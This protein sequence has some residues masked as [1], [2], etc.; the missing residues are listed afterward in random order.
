MIVR[1]PDIPPHI[2]IPP[3]FITSSAEIKKSAESCKRWLNAVYSV[4]VSIRLWRSANTINSGM[5][6]KLEFN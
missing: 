3:L 6:W 5:E 2:R 1:Q 4:S